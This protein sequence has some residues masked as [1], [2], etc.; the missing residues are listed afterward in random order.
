[1]A[2]TINLASKYLPMLDAKYKW[3]SKS[4]VLDAP[5]S[6]IRE[7]MNAKT[8]YIKKLTLQGLGDYSRATG[9]VQGDITV[10]WQSH[11]F[12]QD[13]GRTFTLDA[14]DD[15]ETLG[16]TY[17]EVAGEFIRLHVA[18]ELDAYRF[19]KYA[20]LANISDTTAP[21]AANILQL[22]DDLGASMDS[23]EVPEEGRVLFISTDDYVLLK[24]ADGIQRRL[25]VSVQN[26]GGIERRVTSL[27]GMRLIKVPQGRFYNSF[28]FYDG[29]TGGQEAGGFVPT[30]VTGKKLRFMIIH[31]TASLQV[32]KHA[33]PR[34]FDPAVN[35]SAD[36]WKIDYRIYH[37]AFVPDNKT[38]G[39]AIQVEA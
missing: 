10:E 36:A 11:T 33:V 2:N 21:T 30:P 23:A 27:D 39:I 15:A 35:Q 4:S 22:I 3:E 26:V 29:V 17:L 14:M 24:Q 32:V 31:P 8:I 20:S 1:M 25:D 18:P 12:T 6:A 19:S 9:F 37:D 38:N 34:I 28:D 5:A 7:T 13:R 16:G